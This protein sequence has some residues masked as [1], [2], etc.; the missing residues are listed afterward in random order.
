MT[1]DLKYPFSA[2][3]IVDITTN[4]NDLELNYVDDF[5]DLVISINSKTEE[6]FNITNT[7]LINLEF[8]I[9]D[10]KPGVYQFETLSGEVESFPVMTVETGDNTV[11]EILENCINDDSFVFLKPVGLNADFIDNSLIINYYQ[12]SNDSY[13][14]SIYNSN[15]NLIIPVL[16]NNT[17]S[18]EYRFDINANKLS[19]GQYFLILEYSNKLMSR[20]IQIVK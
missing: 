11:V 17:E 18:G 20:K 5:G 14:L 8:N 6:K 15:G 4:Q 3:E 12:P 7:D 1:L 16:N 19:S 10:A 13:S 9:L 2:F